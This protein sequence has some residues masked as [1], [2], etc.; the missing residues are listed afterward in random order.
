MLRFIG[1]NAMK[2]KNK[3]EYNCRM[4]KKR[5]NQHNKKVKYNHKEEIKS[6]NY[7]K[8]SRLELDAIFGIS[9]FGIKDFTD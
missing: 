1:K 7:H 9:E 3:E 4:S 8:L 6:C 5:E 2:V